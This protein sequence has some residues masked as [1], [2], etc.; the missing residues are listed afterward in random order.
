VEDVGAAAAKVKL[1]Q[2]TRYEG[3]GF[4]VREGDHKNIQS[5]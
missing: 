5:W 3:G 2:Q 1:I 4:A